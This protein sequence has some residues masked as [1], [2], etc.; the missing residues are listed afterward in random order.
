MARMSHELRT[1]LN[2]VLG[3]SRLL[4]NDAEDPLTDTQRMRLLRIDDAGHR[5]L[6]LTDN[7]LEISRQ[8]DAES[9]VNVQEKAQNSTD[10]GEADG[11]GIAAKPSPQTK[12]GPRAFQ[13][14]CVEDNPVNL[15]LVRELLTMRPHI[16]LHCVEDGQSAIDQALRSPPDAIL[17]DLQLPDIS[18]H[19]VHRRLRQAEALRHCRFI[20]LSA[21]ALPDSIAST[22]AAGFDDYWTK[23][24]D[25]D[26]FLKGLDRLTAEA[27]ERR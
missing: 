12:A 1:P 13:L 19:E 18:G 7:L 9:T 21:D 25:F 4:K 15:L 26:A 27:A 16:E 2:A 20:A 22:L 11:S 5:L 8:D 24:I 23:P 17:L 3:F 10:L 14:L 6:S